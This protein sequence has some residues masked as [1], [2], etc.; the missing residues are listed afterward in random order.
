M[1]FNSGISVNDCLMP[2]LSNITLPSLFTNVEI[3]CSFPTGVDDKNERGMFCW[4][5]SY[6]VTCW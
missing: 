4:L 3:H 6:V 1:R 5:A 2:M